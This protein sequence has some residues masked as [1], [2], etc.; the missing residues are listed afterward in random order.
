MHETLKV[1][2]DI[3]YW[4]QSGPGDSGSGNPGR[5]Q[6]VLLVTLTGAGPQEQQLGDDAQ[7][8]V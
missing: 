3:V 5:T 2:I 8:D 1:G 6:P 4:H 7:Q